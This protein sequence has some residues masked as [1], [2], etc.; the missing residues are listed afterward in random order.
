MRSSQTN[1]QLTITQQAT[2]SV[3]S[4][5]P[6]YFPTLITRLNEYSSFG[7][8]YGTVHLTKPKELNGQ[9]QA[10]LNTSGTLMF[11]HPSHNLSDDTWRRFF[12]GLQVVKPD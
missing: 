12:N 5:V 8:I 2:P 6:Q 10:V 4:D 1:T 3:F 7:S 11:V 9:Q